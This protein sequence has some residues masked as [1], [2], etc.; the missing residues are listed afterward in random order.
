[1]AAQVKPME[2]RG[3]TEQ[4]ELMQHRTGMFPSLSEEMDRW[5]NETLPR[6]WLYP[7]RWAWS[8]LPDLPSPFEGRV[9]RVDLL[10][11]KKEIVLRAELPGVEKK[12][13]DVSM[14]EHS[15]TIRATTHYEEEKEEGQYHRKEMSHGEFQRVVP[16]P[17][18]IETDKVNAKFKDGVLELKIPKAK[19]ARRKTVDIH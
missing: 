19:P 16:L 12:D 7:M 10:D 13:L 4:T 17:E 11:R 15:V 9:P 3:E 6:R 18:E 1:M 8:G 2:K 5:F 14:T